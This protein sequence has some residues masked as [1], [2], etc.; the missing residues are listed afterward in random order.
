MPYPTPIAECDRCG[1]S[2]KISITY[3]PNLEHIAE[4]IR[5]VP[6]ECG[7]EG[8]RKAMGE[9]VE[10]QRNLHMFYGTRCLDDPNVGYRGLAL[11]Q[12]VEEIAADLEAAIR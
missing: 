4:H 1:K 11:W 8:L 3:F 7:N 9:A 12:A 6:C 5:I 2:L 10:K